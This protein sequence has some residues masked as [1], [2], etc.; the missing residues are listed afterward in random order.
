MVGQHL[1]RPDDELDQGVVELQE[2]PQPGGGGRGAQGP[3]GRD[4]HLEPTLGTDAGLAGPEEL[5]QVLVKLGDWLHFR[6]ATDL[7]GSRF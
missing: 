1:A 7:G 3:G 6:Q 2:V 4:D 5:Q